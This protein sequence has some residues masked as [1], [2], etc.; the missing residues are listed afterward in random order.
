MM[1]TT[2]QENDDKDDATPQLH[3]LSWPLGQVSQKV[4]NLNDLKGLKSMYISH[5][6][7]CKLKYLK[8]NGPL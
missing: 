1:M 7:M 2:M 3:I 4:D 8:C 5:T 6:K